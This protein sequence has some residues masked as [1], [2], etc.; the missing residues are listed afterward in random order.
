MCVNCNDSLQ[1]NLPVAPSGL[2]GTDGDSAY[3]YIASATDT[4]GSGFTYPAV[5]DPP[6]TLPGRYFISIINTTAPLTNPVVGDFGTFTRV[7][8]INGATGATGAAGTNG[9]DGVNGAI[10]LNYKW[11][12]DT[13]A[14]P[15]TAG[16]VKVSNANVGIATSLYIN[17]TDANS[18]V[19]GN[20]LARMIASTSTTKSIV[21]ITAKG[22]PTTFAH[23]AV[24]GGSLLSGTYYIAAITPLSASSTAPFTLNDD[25]VFSFSV[26]GDIGS[27]G[28]TG[29]AGPT[30]PQGP[31]GSANLVRPGS[32]TSYTFDNSLIT[33]QGTT[34]T[35]YFQYSAGTAIPTGGGFKCLDSS[36]AATAVKSDVTMIMI[37][38]EDFGATDYSSV[39][40][41]IG[42]NGTIDFDN[43]AG[44]T[45]SYDILDAVYTSGSPGYLTL[46]VSLSA[47]AG[48]FLP[49]LSGNYDVSLSSMYS[50]TLANQNYNRILLNNAGTTGGVINQNLV[51]LRAPQ[52]AAAGTLMVVEVGAAA[53]TGDMYITYGYN[54]SGTTSAYQSTLAVQVDYAKSVSHNNAYAAS[55]PISIELNTAGQSALLQFYVVAS[56]ASPYKKSLAFMGANIYSR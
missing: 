33:D 50:L 52:T 39:M 37:S 40:S 21:T 49:G 32:N 1:V 8:G 10:S 17:I 16:Y 22:D 24:T 46:Y 7:V 45:A 27:I 54:E 55:S 6:A 19:V 15:P 2:N 53:G 43:T 29:P 5:L 47:G 23:F 26:V 41:G 11:S 31:A 18:Y 13:S 25:V 14:S 56:N 38:T 36:G 34:P 28:A 4:A 35:N 12:N 51:L 30:G 44:S 20:V 48:S 9:A 42:T 3:V